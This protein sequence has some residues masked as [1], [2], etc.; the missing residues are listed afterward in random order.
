LD[1]DLNIQGEGKFVQGTGIAFLD[2]NNNGK[3]DGGEKYVNSDNNVF[4]KTGVSNNVQFSYYDFNNNNSFDTGDSKVS[5]KPN[6]VTVLNDGSRLTITELTNFKK[7]PELSFSDLFNYKFAGE[8]NLGLNAK[9][10]INNDTNFP[11][12]SVDL[13]VNLPLFNY[14]NQDEGRSNGL[15]VNFNNITV[16]LGGFISDVARPVIETADRIITP[17]KPVILA[18]NADTKILG[19]LGLE[20]AFD[21]DGKPGVSILEIAQTLNPGNN[22]KINKAINFAT[23]VTKIVEIVN[24]LRTAS[25]TTQNTTTID[26]KSVPGGSP[27]TTSAPGTPPTNLFNTDFG[28]GTNNYKTEAKLLLNDG[29]LS[30]VFDALTL[31]PNN[32]TFVITHGFQSGVFGQN[33]QF[34]ELGTA[35]HNYFK[36]LNQGVNVILWDWNTEA[37]GTDYKA[38]ANKVGG[39]GD[40]LAAFLLAANINP[41]K[42]QLIG[43]SLGAHVMGNAGEKYKE[44]TRISGSEKSINMIV[45]LDPAGPLF[46][47]DF[48]PATLSNDSSN[49]LDETA[50]R[51]DATDADRV[52]ALHTSE[53]LGFDRNLGDLD[54]FVNWSDPY[55]PGA[56]FI[57]ENFLLS[58][59]VL[60]IV[61]RLAL[62]L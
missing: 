26:I 25:A 11:S 13:A 32:F 54:L 20:S 48:N 5:D 40:E 37:S 50:N 52:V 43:H 15:S 41:S 14:G 35:I 2:A 39:I 9:T 56:S 51:L 18:L 57:T 29:T 28:F 12:V 30:T 42:T 61:K 38:N 46:E 10:S 31:N 16:D 24:L 53:T 55:Q 33:P 34:R 60:V 27:N 44:L 1:G 36:S 4:T 17:I 58:H 8:A 23:T 21:R 22:A 45:G 19:Y 7:D 49:T 62:L 3:L 59:K 6:I 47:S